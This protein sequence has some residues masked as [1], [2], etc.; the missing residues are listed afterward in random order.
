[1]SSPSSPAPPLV[2]SRPAHAQTSATVDATE[3][4]VASAFGP[5]GAAARAS[6]SNSP[7][8]AAPPRATVPASSLFPVGHLQEELLDYEDAA[9]E[10]VE[11][12]AG[13]VEA[14]KDSKK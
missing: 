2:E 6:S 3:S 4:L 13:E 7:R 5:P 10:A 14:A 12:P 1:M 8:L 11:K 9:V